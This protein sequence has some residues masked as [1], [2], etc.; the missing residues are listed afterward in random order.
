MDVGG[1]DGTLLAAILAANPRMSGVLYDSAAGMA[2]AEATL[3]RAGVAD[4]C[5]IEAGDFFTSVPAGGE[6]YV[7]KSIVHGWG[8]DRAARILGNCADAMADGGRI[9]MIDLV[10]PEAVAPGSSLLPYLTDLGLLV[11]GRGRERTRDDFVRLCGEVGLTLREVTQLPPTGFHWI[12][13]SPGLRR[14]DGAPATATAIHA[15][16]GTR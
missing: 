13:A 6:L 16:D 9:A 3:R 10:L 4:R 11:N 2:E 12:E 14:R 8:D 5:Q 1:G 7:L 15:D